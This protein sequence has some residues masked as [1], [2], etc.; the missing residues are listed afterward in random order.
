MHRALVASSELRRIL[1]I[2]AS[3]KQKAE[4]STG[5]LLVGLISAAGLLA[6]TVC[7]AGI[8]IGGFLLYRANAVGD[9]EKQIIGRWQ[10]AG[11]FGNHRHFGDNP[12][13]LEFKEGGAFNM[14]S[15][16][17]AIRYDNGKWKM[18][19]KQGS[20]ITVEVTYQ[21]VHVHPNQDIPFPPRTETFQLGFFSSK[22]MWR[23][24]NL[25]AAGGWK[26]RRL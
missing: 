15:G 6:V 21:E 17:A 14:I 5:L 20:G 26:Y 9:P 8:G 3:R 24:F 25:E 16:N 19:S 10:F 7:C 2:M 23:R 13:T 12:P 11:T 4:G 1:S 18:V 22:E